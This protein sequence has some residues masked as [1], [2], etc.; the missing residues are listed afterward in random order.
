MDF[1]NF[2]NCTSRKAK[3]QNKANAMK[4]I[5]YTYCN[6]NYQNNRFTI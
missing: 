4:K 1:I 5:P 6:Y 2:F 3:M